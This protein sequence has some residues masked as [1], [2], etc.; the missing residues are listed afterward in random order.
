MVKLLSAGGSDAGDAV[1]L[2]HGVGEQLGAHRVEIGIG[3]VVGDLKLE[4]AAGAHVGDARKAQSLQRMVDRL[5]LRVE[6]PRFERSEEH[7]SELQSLMRISYAVFALK[8]NIS[9]TSAN[10]RRTEHHHHNNHTQIVT[11]S[12]TSFQHKTHSQ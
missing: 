8:N 2:D 5:A 12:H 9:P 4:K 11:P 3:H 1:I 10:I 6:H 7:T